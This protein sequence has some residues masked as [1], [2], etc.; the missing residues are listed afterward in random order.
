MFLGGIVD[1]RIA[2]WNT[3]KNPYINKYI[4]TLILDYGID[5]IAIAEYSSSSQDLLK[6]LAQYGFVYDCYS[7]LECKRITWIG[8]LSSFEIG[9][10][11]KHH[12]IIVSN[13]G[14]NLCAVHYP[15]KLYT[16]SNTRA[17]SFSK[18]ID[19]INQ[20]ES[21]I[22]SKKTIIFGDFNEDPFEDNCLSANLFHGLPSIDDARKSSRVVQGNSYDMFYN[23]MWNCFGDDDYPPGT[24]YYQSSKNAESF[25]H[26][27]DQVIFRP[28][29]HPFFKRDSLSIVT[30]LSCA[31]LNDTNGLPNVSISDHFP[32]VFELE[33]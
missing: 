5:I 32:I 27:F 11:Q 26:I 16:D 28:S 29:I 10:Q 4:C 6:T 22:D 20:L 15:S 30:E 25:W 33:D 17:I 7:P 12:S 19:D 31:H 14:Y 2:F 18:T 1:L 24:Y 8:N 3:N 13:K 9:P 21:E 23:P